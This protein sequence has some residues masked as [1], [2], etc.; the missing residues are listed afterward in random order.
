MAE[1][2]KKSALTSRI[3]T[4][5]DAL[6]T[7]K[8]ASTGFFVVAA[9]MAALSFLIGF[10]VLVDAALFVVLAFLVR[11]F[12]S[13]VAAVLL[14]LLAVADAAATVANKLGYDAGG[15]SNIFL[16][17]IVLWAAIRAVE[18]TFKLRSLTSPSQEGAAPPVA[19]GPK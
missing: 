4:R 14:L 8:E 11:R 12:H 10:T 17:A 13:R 2:K 3:T 7:I 5:E 6:A 9:I 15:G 1:A 18:A 19:F 16:A